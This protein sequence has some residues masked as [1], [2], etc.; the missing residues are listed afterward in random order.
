MTNFWPNFKDNPLFAGLFAILLIA[1]ICTLVFIALNQQKQNYY[2][3]KSPETQRIITITGEGKVTAIP[4]IAMVSLGLETEKND[5]TEAQNQNSEIM[6]NLIEKLKNLSIAKEDIQ[7]TNYSIYPRY[8]WKDGIQILQGYIVNQNVTVKIR[9]TDKVEQVLRIAGELKLNQIG[10]LTFGI[11][12]P[13]SYRQAAR[14]K[15][16][17]NAKIKSGD[18]AKVMNVKLGKIVSFSESEGYMPAPYPVYTK[19]EGIGGG[20]GTPSVEAG[21]QEI[22]VVATITYELD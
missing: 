3:G 13:E 4:D 21:S 11:D 10:G 18:L 14:L 19:A 9:Q 8:D 22:T 7:T 20:G 15:A 1:L 5:I 6:N 12:D 17:E 16:L 2:I